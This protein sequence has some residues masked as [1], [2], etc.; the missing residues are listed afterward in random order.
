MRYARAGGIK[1]ISV[2]Y[3]SRRTIRG[4]LNPNQLR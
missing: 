4:Q 1:H 3:Q 2:Q